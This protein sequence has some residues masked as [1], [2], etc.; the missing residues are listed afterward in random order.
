MPEKYVLLLSL[1]LNVSLAAYGKP[2]SVDSS[3]ENVQFVF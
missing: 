1:L 2:D 3:A